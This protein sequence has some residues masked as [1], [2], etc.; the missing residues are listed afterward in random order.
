MGQGAN[1][2]DNHIS[3]FQEEI[4]KAAGADPGVFFNWFDESG[5]D[6]DTS[7]NKGLCEF[8]YYFL[9]PL[10]KRVKDTKSKTALEI[11]YGGGR[12]L[13]AAAQAFGKV[14]GVDIHQNAAVVAAELEK[15]N[16]RN[17]QLLQSKGKELPVE[18]AS[19]D[20]VYSF[21]VLQHVEKIDVFHSYLYEAHRVLKKGAHAILFFGRL[22]T[23]SQNKRNGMRYRL[24]RILEATLRRGYL[25]VPAR[26]N[27]TNL[28]ISANYAKR[29]AEELG[30][31]V[32]GSGVSRK[33]PDLRVFGG[34]NFLIL[35]KQ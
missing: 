7:F 35:G 11:G 12:L 26:V 9:M 15:R 32:L 19:I 27:C 6:V 29:K 33:V 25:E 4:Q 24:D 8:S 3:G 31:V 30:F 17:F 14:V 22:S 34:Q 16:V 1:I 20:F 5:G 2:T 21:I 18:E 10:L 23:L 13:A 28:K